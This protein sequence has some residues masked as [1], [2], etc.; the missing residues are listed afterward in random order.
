MPASPI[1]VAC[2]APRP[3]LFVS[4]CFLAFDIWYEGPVIAW[5]ACGAVA[6]QCIPRYYGALL[7]PCVRHRRAVRAKV[8][9]NCIDFKKCRV[10]AAK[11]Q[12]NRRWIIATCNVYKAGSHFQCNHPPQPRKM[13]RFGRAK[14][15]LCKVKKDQRGDLPPWSKECRM[16]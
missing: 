3:T 14:G 1:P 8:K 16:L 13:C 4:T 2:I 6:P 5:G 15:A 10:A 9:E 11:R 12:Q 7:W